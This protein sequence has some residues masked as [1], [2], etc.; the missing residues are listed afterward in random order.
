MDEDPE[1][2]VRDDDANLP[3]MAERQGQAPADAIPIPTNNSQ[4]EI[5]RYIVAVGGK[6][7]LLGMDLW[8]TENMP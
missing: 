2:E 1:I 4:E 5:D 6:V 3:G 7:N 8:K